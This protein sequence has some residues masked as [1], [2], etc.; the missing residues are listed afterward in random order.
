MRRFATLML[1]FGLAAM[2][3]GAC[4]ADEAPT[5]PLPTA[6]ISVPLPVQAASTGGCPQGDLAPLRVNWDTAHRSLSL[7]GEKFAFPGG[8]TSRELPSGRLEIVAPDGTVV[9]HDGDKVAVGGA[10][11]EHICRVYWV[12][13]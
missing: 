1:A 3:V 8:F 9:A 2:L 11:Y 5:Y 12:S 4:S 6:A 10:D 13:Y 7:G